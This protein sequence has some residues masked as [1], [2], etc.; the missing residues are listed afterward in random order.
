[1]K[2]RIIKLKLNQGL[3]WI[4]KFSERHFNRQALAEPEAAESAEV[5]HVALVSSFT[6]VTTGTKNDVSH[7]FQFSSFGFLSV[8]MS[9]S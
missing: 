5:S 6:R 4:F 7:E 8:A 3:I 2:Y 1:M 9:G